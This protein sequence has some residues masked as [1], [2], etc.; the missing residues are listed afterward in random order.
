MTQQQTK[1]FSPYFDIMV[2]HVQL[3][4]IKYSIIHLNSLVISKITYTPAF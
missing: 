4:G 3:Q 2:G 1:R